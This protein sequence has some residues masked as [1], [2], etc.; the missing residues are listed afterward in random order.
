[1]ATGAALSLLFGM[2]LLDNFFTGPVV[3][4]VAGVVIGII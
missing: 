3:G 1:M 2:M 4:A